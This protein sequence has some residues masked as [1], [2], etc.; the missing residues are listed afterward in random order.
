[1]NK[2]I[3]ITLAI[4][5]LAS[6]TKETQVDSR[7]VIDNWAYD[8][9]TNTAEWVG[10][11]PSPTEMI[12]SE[13]T[14]QSEKP[15]TSVNRYSRAF[16][17][18]AA[19]VYFKNW[20]ENYEEFDS[21]CMT[22]TSYSEDCDIDGE[23]SPSDWYDWNSPTGYKYGIYELLHQTNDGEYTI[24]TINGARYNMFSFATEQGDNLLIGQFGYRTVW[25]GPNEDVDLLYIWPGRANYWYF[26]VECDADQV[27]DENKM[28]FS[29]S[30]L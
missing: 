2:L 4:F 16:C 3:L 7:I 14:E 27:S 29:T 11:T 26:V 21:R 13:I 23:D 6:C 19:W 1:M 8:E 18:D 22:Q 17:G 5:M 30:P 20:G 10:K 9:N 28:I 24:C 12:E 25:N 15:P